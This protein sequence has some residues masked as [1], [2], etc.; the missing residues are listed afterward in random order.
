MST[1]RILNL[2]T[3][4]QQFQTRITTCLNDLEKNRIYDFD[5]ITE[6]IESWI[7]ATS[8][9]AKPDHALAFGITV[10][11][12]TYLIRLIKLS[13]ANSSKIIS[14]PRLT[15]FNKLMKNL[16]SLNKII[17]SH[18][19]KNEIQGW[20]TSGRI[21]AVTSRIGFISQKLDV[22]LPEIFTEP[23]VHWIHS[24]RSS[25]LRLKMILDGNNIALKE[26]IMEQ[27]FPAPTKDSPRLKPFLMTR[28]L[29]DE[30]KLQI[31]NFY[32]RKYQH[33]GMEKILKIRLEYADEFRIFFKLYLKVLLQTHLTRPSL[34]SAFEHLCNTRVTIKRFVKT[35]SEELN[36]LEHPNKKWLIE[37][38]NVRFNLNVTA[39]S[40]DHVEGDQVLIDLTPLESEL[41]H[42]A[43]KRPRLDN[44]AYE[45]IQEDILVNIDNPNLRFMYQSLFSDNEI[46]GISEISE[47]IPSD[48][49][50]IADNNNHTLPFDNDF[51][52]LETPL[53]EC[54]TDQNAQDN[55]LTDY[56]AECH[57]MLFEENDNESVFSPV[58]E[59]ATII[60]NHAN[61]PVDDNSSIHTSPKPFPYYSSPA[62]MWQSAS[63]PTFTS[64]DETT[65]LDAASNESMN[66]FSPKI[67]S[68]S[69]SQ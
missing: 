29:S 24:G 54:V 12:K 5:F 59:V 65:T 63:T 48:D 33:I 10:A 53:R 57:R 58:T 6:N 39:P 47:V 62:S 21:Y 44:D 50:F 13:A 42:G 28:I 14:A 1:N 25:M 34:L 19:F 11:I 55:V 51:E 60:S 66:E 52:T 4:A 22:C 37:A 40:N 26:N 3:P 8:N 49:E 67:P 31:L 69:K 68:Q 23:V 16:I 64:F 17:I 56:L 27:I 38:A 30:N 18:F 43:S 32:I 2:A 41:E 45:D 36:H 15:M 46:G 20:L 35:L 61:E 7:I 9:P